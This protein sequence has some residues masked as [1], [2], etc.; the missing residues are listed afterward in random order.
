[1]LMVTAYAA[2]ILVTAAVPGG[3]EPTI[4]PFLCSTR[5]NPLTRPISC[6]Y[7]PTHRNIDEQ[8]Q[9]LHND[10]DIDLICQ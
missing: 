6:A 5:T 3:P 2:P 8:F 7:L 1:M 4:M 10:R 9:L